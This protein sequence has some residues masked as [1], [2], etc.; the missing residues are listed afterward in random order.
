LQEDLQYAKVGKYWYG[1]VQSRGNL[2]FDIL[3]DTFLKDC[4]CIFDL[5]NKRF[6]CVQRIEPES[7]PASDSSPAAGNPAD[8]GSGGVVPSAAGLKD[9]F[10][11]WLAALLKLLGLSC[12]V[13]RL[14][15]LSGWL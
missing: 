15:V 6:G 3:G 2:G 8:G 12:R 11:Q 5:G 13:T 9:L 1:G 7:K 4:Y 14:V 10:N